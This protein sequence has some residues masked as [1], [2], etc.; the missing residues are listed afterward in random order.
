MIGRKEK[1]KEGKKTKINAGNITSGGK[2]LYQSNVAKRALKRAGK[3][4]NLKGHISEIM[5]CDIQNINPKNI[6]QGKKAMLTKS[7]TAGRDDIVIMKNGRRVG[8]MQVKDTISKSGIKDTVDRVER[9]QYRRTKLVGT[10]ETCEAYEKEVAKRGGKITQKMSS[11][12]IS[13][14]ETELIAAKALGGKVPENIP[15][16]TKQAAK[17]AKT[18]A[19]VSGGIEAV[20]SVNAVRKGEKDIS[21]ATVSIAKEAVY[22][23]ATA[24]VADTVGTTATMIVAA[25]PLAPAAPAV[26]LV[27]GG[28]AG[29]ATDKA[30]RTAEDVV[31]DRIPASKQQIEKLSDDKKD[32]RNLKI[33][34]QDKY[35]MNKMNRGKITSSSLLKKRA[36][37]K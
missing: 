18:G 12:G 20:K 15:K 6:A 32:S 28:V 25:T 1:E 4:K 11:T 16:I 27:A 8:G 37:H 14:E 34:S 26:G 22:G 2:H 10:I 29:A 13:S 23:G 36:S 30:L 24:Y 3:N 17:S 7:P 33:K 19:A 21:E 31:N 5:T 35:I 9:G